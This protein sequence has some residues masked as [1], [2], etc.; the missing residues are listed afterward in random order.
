MG[1]NWPTNHLD[2][3]MIR[4]TL[5]PHWAKSS[6]SQCQRVF[7][8]RHVLRSTSPASASSFFESR[9]PLYLGQWYES[10]DSLSLEPGDRITS[11]VFWQTQE[12]DAVR[13][14]PQRE[15]FGRIA[16]IAI[17]KTGS[18]PRRLDVCQQDK[19]DLLSYSFREN[20]YEH[21][22]GYAP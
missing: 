14:Q 6:V 10:I 21:L 13:A 15:N 20:A 9:S 4:S 19:I 12:M 1:S 7:P 3:I 8:A 2:P 18:E 16:G 17:Q 11:L 22:V 5:G